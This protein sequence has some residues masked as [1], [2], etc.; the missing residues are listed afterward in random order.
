MMWQVL[1]LSWGMGLI[2]ILFCWWKKLKCVLVEI[3]GGD[4]CCEK[5]CCRVFDKVI[6]VGWCELLF[7][8]EVLVD[9]DEVVGLVLLEVCIEVVM[10]E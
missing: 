1:G 2:R 8:V 7:G 9:V 10:G 4:D 3:D 5:V 6:Q